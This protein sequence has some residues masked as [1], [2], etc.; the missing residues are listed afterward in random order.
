MSFRVQKP[1]GWVEEWVSTDSSTATTTTDSTESEPYIKRYRSSKNNRKSNCKESYTVE[2]SYTVK[3]LRRKNNCKESYTVE[4]PRRKNKCKESFTV[5]D[6]ECGESALCTD[7]ERSLTVTES[8]NKVYDQVSGDCNGKLSC[9]CAYVKW[10]DKCGNVYLSLIK[11]APSESQLETSI[12]RFI[13]SLSSLFNTTNNTSP[14]SVT[15]INMFGWFDDSTTLAAYDSMS[16]VPRVAIGAQESAALFK[17]LFDSVKMA[18]PT[19]TVRILYTKRI[20]SN[21]QVNVTYDLRFS[22]TDG[23]G[24]GSQRV[25]FRTQS[26]ILNC[27]LTLP[28]VDIGDLFISDPLLA[29]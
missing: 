21:D 8:C 16:L 29:L 14:L 27:G 12:N 24:T 7:T 17:A 1:K 11:S 28:R 9:G 22:W 5:E 23:T 18:H 13:N 6:P 15:A 19:A 26:H 4:D 3:D 25:V 10:T 20:T 2:D